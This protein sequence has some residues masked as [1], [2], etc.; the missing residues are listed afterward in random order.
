MSINIQTIDK[1]MAQMECS[2]CGF[3]FQTP[4]VSIPSIM[5]RPC[6]A[7]RDKGLEYHIYTVCYADNRPASY[8]GEEKPRAKPR[9]CKGCRKYISGMC[10]GE[11]CLYCSQHNT[12]YY[13]EEEQP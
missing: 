9:D 5:I 12:I 2:E 11:D 7:C 6:W 10:M 8:E 3:R 4:V 1:G 13:E